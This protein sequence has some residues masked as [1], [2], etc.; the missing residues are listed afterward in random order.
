MFEGHPTMRD[1]GLAFVDMIKELMQLLLE[2]R[3]VIND[4]NRENRMSCTV[5]L[6]VGSAAE[7]NGLKCYNLIPQYFMNTGFTISHRN[8]F[9]VINRKIS[10]I[11]Y[12]SICMFL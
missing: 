10:F 2:Y 5:N 8:F 4:E 1:Q 7:Q 3:A 12:K 6:L 11:C 9:A